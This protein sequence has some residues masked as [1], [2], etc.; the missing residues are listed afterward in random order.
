MKKERKKRIK[1]KVAAVLAAMMLA[2]MM[3]TAAYAAT[4]GWSMTGLSARVYT[5]SAGN[6]EGAVSPEQA[7]LNDFSVRVS[8]N[9]KTVNHAGNIMIT[10]IKKGLIW[11]TSAQ[12][13]RISINA[14]AMMTWNFKGKT[15]DKGNYYFTISPDADGVDIILSYFGG[16]CTY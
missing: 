5:N 2:G 14:T 4:V 13:D 8:Y 12:S 3:S 15:F 6:H 1:V 11:N 9:V 7:P 10:A 16:V